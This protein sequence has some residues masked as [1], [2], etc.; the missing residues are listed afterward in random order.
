MLL[1][2]HLKEFEPEN[3]AIWRNPSVVT[4]GWRVSGIPDLADPEVAPL[5]RATFFG[6]IDAIP[7]LFD[8]DVVTVESAGREMRGVD[9]FVGYLR[10]FN[11]AVPGAKLNAVRAIDSGDT[12]VIEGTYTGTHTGPLASPQGSLIFVHACIP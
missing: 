9:A 4:G 8:R 10:V 12:V 1:E 3:P 2:Q 7:T 11:T 6:D 5:A